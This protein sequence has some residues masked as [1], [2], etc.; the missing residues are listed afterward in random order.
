MNQRQLR[1]SVDV[2]QD[3]VA[4]P[5]EQAVLVF[6]SV[7]ELLINVA[8]HAGTK[9]ASIRMR[10]D[11]EGIRVEVRDTGDGFDSAVV[12]PH[13]GAHPAK[14]GLFSI[15]ERMKAFDGTLELVTAPGKGTT[16]LLVL[17]LEE[18]VEQRAHDSVISVEAKA[19]RTAMERMPSLQK[20]LTVLLVDDHAMMRQGL[21]SVL[22][23]HTDIQI[24]GEASDGQEA[25]VMA[26]ALRPAVVVMDINMPRLNG[27]EATARIKGQYPDIRVIGLSVNAGP[28]NREA[29]LKAGADMLLTKEAA[30]EEL[31]RGIQ[32][33]VPRL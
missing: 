24:I 18:V 32:A 31:Y 27:I 29:M 26:D 14:F 19:G 5:E 4:V 28:N 33:V 17:P 30:V 2:G 21:R 6:Q 25:V 22:E 23:A 13:D 9:E 11:E 16:A 3:F 7:R 20:V 8:K 12:R 1:V 10:R 15:R